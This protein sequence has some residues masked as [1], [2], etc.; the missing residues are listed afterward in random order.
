MD[1][2]QMQEHWHQESFVNNMLADLSKWTPLYMMFLL[3]LFALLLKAAY[4]KQRMNYMQH[5]VHAV[6]INS[7]FLVLVS[8]PVAIMIYSVEMQSGI[9]GMIS[10]SFKIFFALIFIYMLLSSRTV[11]REGWFKTVMKTLLVFGGFSLL[12]LILALAL[13]LWRICTHYYQ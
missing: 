1:P 10:W 11:Y 13:V 12:A 9:N 7:F 3:P 4:R 5:F 8:I 6:H 2:E